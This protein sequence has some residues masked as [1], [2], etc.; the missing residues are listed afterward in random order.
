M[1]SGVETSQKTPRFLGMTTA[2][3]I[4]IHDLNR[5]Q[6][7]I[8]I[9]QIIIM[10]TITKLGLAVLL[11]MATAATNHTQ[12]QTKEETIAWIK[13]KLENSTSF[14]NSSWNNMKNKSITECAITYTFKYY[15]NHEQTL[16][17]KKRIF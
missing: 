5:G 12:E 4:I 17:V 6:K 11:F 14:Y 3:I 15:G 9:K 1:S 10:K 13:E 8:N 2:T 16:P 7:K